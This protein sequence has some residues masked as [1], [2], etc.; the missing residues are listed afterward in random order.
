[1]SVAHRPPGPVRRTTAP[2]VCHAV[3]ALSAATV[4]AFAGV[5]AL[6][7]AAPQV[8]NLPA[9]PLEQSLN[10]LAASTG[11]QIMF[12]S[13]V[14]EGRQAPAVQ[15]QLSAQQALQRLLDGSG[16]VA[17][18]ADGGKTFVI[19]P[20]PGGAGASPSGAA[21]T[22]STVTVTAEGTPSLVTE[23]SGSY[24]FRASATA[25]GLTLSLRDTPQSV[26]VVT[27]ERIDDQSMTTVADALRNTTGISLQPVDRGRNQLSARGFD[28]TQFQFD[29]V[30]VQTGN[31]GV[32]AAKTAIYDRI[33]VIRGAT[34]LLTGPGDPSAT[35]NLVRKHA[36]SKTFEGTASLE[37]GSWKT[38][39][40]MVDLSVPLNRDA[41]ARAR[42]VARTGA[43]EGFI[44]LERTR[45]ATLYGVVDIDVDAQTRLS[46]G[47]SEQRDTRRGVLWVGLPYWYADGSAAQWSRSQTTAAR[48]NRWDT[49]ERTV[50]AQ[51]ER[52]LPHRWN[53]K[54]DLSYR[55]QE[56]EQKALWNSGEVDRFTGLGL[57]GEPYHWL[58]KPEQTALTLTASGPFRLLGRSH[59]ATAGLMHS[60]MKGGWSNRDPLAD[61]VPLGSLHHWNGQVPD[62]PMGPRYQSDLSTTTQTA[63][64]AATRRQLADRLKLIAGARLTHWKQD[65]QN[66]E[67]LE[68]AY[69]HSRERGVFTPYVGLVFDLNDTVSAYASYTEVFKPQTGYRDRNGNYLDPVEGKNYEAGL[70]AEFLDG[71][72]N[73]SASVF[74]VE[75]DNFAVRDGQHLVPGTTS[76]A[77]YAAQGVTT[78]G[79]E[80]ELAGRLARGWEI[81]AGWTHYSARDAE[82]RNVALD[83][84]RRLLRFF[85]TYALDGSL[86]GLTLG[87]GLNW[88]SRQLTRGAHPVTGL[89]VDVGQGAYALVDLMA[90]YELNPRTT[91][92]LNIH[93]ALDKTYRVSNYWNT[94]TYGEPRKVTLRMNY[95]F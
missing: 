34:G 82:G 48:W 14:V 42:L 78:K 72:L 84:P 88:Q 65:T 85:T 21:P 76:Q 24:T 2:A 86:R 93:N 16:L 95:R 92:Q 25:T 31:V 91:L 75:Q 32:E 60:R 20:A 26:S 90:R 80:M 94:F 83:H 5:A 29:G 11:V 6:A 66:G 70:K 22:L 4:L 7:Q 81:S 9:S 69:R 33:D 50:F 71:A 87:G 28:I 61:P 49:T 64:Y 17:R 54:A 19:E 46:L 38:R 52:Q 45:D 8:L 56:E 67:G 44:D 18:P 51:F 68:A 27:R 53:L 10:R 15:G 55:K 40:G 23:G 74:R 30:P 1:M 47:A 35:I 79:Y 77:Y 13:A 43:Q 57:V 3:R 37:L 63:L 12:A 62:Y 59:E 89:D 36:L 39:A 58:T 41:S 73:A